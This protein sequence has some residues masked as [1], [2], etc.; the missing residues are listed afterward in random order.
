MP[1]QGA[2]DEARL[3]TWPTPQKAFLDTLLVLAIVMGT[4]AMLLSVN[5]LLTN[6]SEWWYHRGG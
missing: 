3:I 6:G 1:L 4:G 5:I 2:L